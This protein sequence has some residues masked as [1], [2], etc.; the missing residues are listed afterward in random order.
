MTLNVNDP[1]VLRR[2]GAWGG[3]ITEIRK[4]QATVAF[5]GGGTGRLPVEELVAAPEDKSWPPADLETK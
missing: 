3:R 5:H 4:G 1:V 2:D